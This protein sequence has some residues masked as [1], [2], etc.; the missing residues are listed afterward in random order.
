MTPRRQIRADFDRDTLTIYQAYS[1]AIADAALREGRL[2]APFS[3]SRMTW[4]KPSFLWLMA[5]SGWGRKRGQERT[6]AVRIT[7]EGWLSALSEG[8]LTAYEPD[9]HGDFG[10]W[11]DAFASAVVHVQW[12]PERGMRGG[13]LEH[14]SIQVGISRHRIR[15][16]TDDWTVE[17]RDLT[18]TVDKIRRL[19]DAGEITAARRLLPPERPLEVPADIAA[20]LGM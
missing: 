4:I 5:R 13:S 12:D 14:D 20:R 8:V 16:F 19:R 6:L 9:V 1:D 2:V 10:A 17:V 18:A 11:E 15:R 3:F 7:R